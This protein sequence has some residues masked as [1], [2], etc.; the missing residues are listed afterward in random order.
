MS[1]WYYVMIKAKMLMPTDQ[2]KCTGQS[3]LSPPASLQVPRYDHSPL[4][5]ATM[6]NSGDLIEQLKVSVTSLHELRKSAASGPFRG[7]LGSR[8]QS[9]TKHNV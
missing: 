3:C 6:P 2:R 8:G 1:T 4:G 7:E 5:V 9:R